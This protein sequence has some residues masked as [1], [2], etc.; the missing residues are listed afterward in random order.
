VIVYLYDRKPELLVAQGD[1]D[2][3]A[4]ASDVPPCQLSAV[5]VDPRGHQAGEPDARNADPVLHVTRV[6]RTHGSDVRERYVDGGADPP[7]HAR[8]LDL[9]RPPSMD[10]RAVIAERSR[11]RLNRSGRGL[12]RASCA[13]AT[14]PT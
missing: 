7:S 14:R 1:D 2:C 6:C 11:G 8:S 9:S 3:R 10:M 4:A 5:P 12:N 13:L